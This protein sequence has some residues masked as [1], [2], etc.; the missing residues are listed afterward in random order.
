MNNKIGI[1]QSNYIPW[2]GFFELVSK[3]DFFVFLESVQYTKN[4]WRNRN[5]IRINE[6]PHWLTIPV[7]TNNSLSL[8]LCDVEII[9]H[10]WLEKHLVTIR[11]SYRDRKAKQ[12]LTD[13]LDEIYSP[14]IR[15]IK[16]LSEINIYILKKI[17]AMLEINTKTSIYE[18]RDN[19]SKQ[20]RV[21]QICKELGGSDYLTTAKG[22]SYLDEE[23]FLAFHL[24][25]E[26]ITYQKSY[27]FLIDVDG[28]SE[29]KYSIIDTVAKVGIEEIRAFIKN[30]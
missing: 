20:E 14:E 4:D 9:D 10:R 8:T 15:E 5:L 24:N 19:Y 16:K 13:F 3:C 25:V 7:R 17:F 28:N 23:K 2:L 12:N 21:L 1:S 18:T 22:R 26:L 27:D 29:A 6:E 30:G 11:H